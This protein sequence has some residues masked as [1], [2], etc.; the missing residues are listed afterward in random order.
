MKRL[1]LVVSILV[2]LLLA[3][4]LAFAGGQRGAEKQTV[5]FFWAGY[6]GLT[7]EYRASLQDAFNAAHPDIDVDIVHTDWDLM[8]D[9]L[10][11]SIAGGK[12]P[13]LSVIGT[14]WLLELMTMDAVDEV[15]QYLSKST[16]D[17]IAPGAMEAKLKGK[18]MGLPVAAGARVLA[19]NP[20]LTTTVPNTMEELREAAIKVHNPPNVYGLIMPGK[21]HTE[22]TDFAYYLYA[23]GGNFFEMEP[24]GSYGKCIVN[25]PEGVKAVTFMNKLAEEDKVV[26]EGY[27]A[28]DRMDS[29]PLFYTGKIAYTFI[30][31]W[32]ESA[33]KNAG[34]SF[35]PKYGQIPPFAGQKQKSLIITDSIAMFKG[36][37]LEAAGKFLD[38]FYQDEWKAKFDEAIGFPPVTISAGKL[39]QFQTP[40]YKVLGE[41]ALNAQGWPLIEEWAECSN[42]IYNAEIEVHLGKKTPKQALDDAAAEI[43][44]L[45]GK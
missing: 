16:V 7:E 23:A 3:A 21:L 8:Y 12:P 18:L 43:D 39:P 34:A 2:V 4:G 35:Q 22:L 28:L 10:T 33:A 36:T 38:F 29:H 30:G 11:T 25:S 24:D 41:A 27:L 37:N 15:T 14:R 32:V 20:D 17:N 44:K 45:R 40:L 13:E 5:T 1:K 31:A 9:K 19:Y 26:Q 42:I 6:D